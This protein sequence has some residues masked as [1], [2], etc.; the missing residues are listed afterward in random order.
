[1]ATPHRSVILAVI[2]VAF[3]QTHLYRM[4]F[5]PLIPT[6]VADLGL[7]YA[8]AGTIQAAYFW[9]YALVQVPIGVIADR[10]G[11]WRVMLTGHARSAA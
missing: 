9:T 1:M 3:M 11:V 8:A 5:A 10:W 7:T 4:A 2:V 6:F